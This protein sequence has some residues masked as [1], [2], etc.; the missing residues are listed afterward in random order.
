[1]E[2]APSSD[3][4]SIIFWLLGVGGTAIGGAVVH[5]HKRISDSSNSLWKAHNEERRINEERWIE[6]AKTRFTKD[7]AS[8][9]EKRILDAIRTS[10]RTH[11]NQTRRVE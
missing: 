6:L 5:I 10:P 2:H 11:Q 8:A 3:V 1:M 7:D 9:M 4:I